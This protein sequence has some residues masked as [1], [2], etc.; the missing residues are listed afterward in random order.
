MLKPSL[1]L[2]FGQSLSMTPQLQQA[3]KLLQ[4]SSVE[5]QQEIQQLFETNPM[6]EK[7]EGNDIQADADN[8]D[9]EN[10]SND[11]LVEDQEIPEQQEQISDELVVDSSWEDVYQEPNIYS[12]SPQEAKTDIYENQAV[13]SSSLHEH[14]QHQLDLLHLSDTDSS[15]GITQVEQ[16]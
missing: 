16:I 9:V 7:D 10:D 11:G 2:R 8:N 6:L 14:L 3:I 13:H 1:Q 4:L 15:V 12:E 5:L